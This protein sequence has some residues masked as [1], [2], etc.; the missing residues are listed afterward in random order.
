MQQALGTQGLRVS[1]F[2][3]RLRHGAA[4]VADHRQGYSASPHTHDCDMLFLPMQGRFEIVDAWERHLQSSPGDFL[5]LGPDAAHATAAQ[6][7][8]QTHLAIYV[9][10]EFWAT[11]LSAQRIDRPPQGLR[12]GSAA[13]G[14]LSRR[15]LDIDNRGLDVDTAAWCGAVVMEAARL[16]A[17][18]A[19]DATPR[20]SRHIAALLADHI[21]TDLDRPLGVDAFAQSQRLSRRQ[22]ERLFRLEYGHSPLAFQQSKRLQRARYLLEHTDESVLSIAQQVGWESGSYLAKALKRAWGLSAAQLRAQNGRDADAPV[23]T[24]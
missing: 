11:A 21:E 2:R 16:C 17:H 9:D 24:K 12:T 6:T 23:C 3:E 14:A 4:L 1:P 15:L 5:W 18:P 22:V 8:R 10:P 7:F 20:S 13:L 19:L